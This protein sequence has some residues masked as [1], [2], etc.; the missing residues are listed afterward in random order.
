LTVYD[1]IL[2]LILFVTSLV[3][4]ITGINRSPGSTAKVIIDNMVIDHLDLSADSGY[5]YDAIHGKITISIAGGKVRV[6]ESD[7]PMKFCMK[8]G[9]AFRTGDVIVCLPAKFMV[10]IENGDNSPVH[11]VTG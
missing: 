8:T 9:A 10:V 1:L 6:S 7:C 4:L 5:T 11:E 2:I 3:F